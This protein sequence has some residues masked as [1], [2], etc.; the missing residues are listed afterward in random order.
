[1]SK[2]LMATFGRASL[3]LSTFAILVILAVPKGAAFDCTPCT[4]ADNGSGTIDY[5]SPCPHR[6]AS[7]QFASIID[8]LPQ[9]TT[10]DIPMEIVALSLSS[11]TPGGTLNGEVAVFDGQLNLP[12]TGTGTLAG[13]ARNVV[14]T[15][16]GEIHSA[17]RTPG[18]PIQSFDTDMFRLQG[19]ITGD[20]DFD[21][22]R[23]T[24]GTAF[25]MP[26]G[27]HVTILKAAGSN[28]W[29]GDG[30]F[31]I[32]YRIDFVGHPG[33]PLGG[34]SGST[35]GTIRVYQGCP[36]W[37]AGD[38]HK[39]HFPQLPNEAGWDVAAT[40]PRFLADDFRCSETG[41]IKDIHFWG[42]WLNGQRGRIR[43]FRLMIL[44]DV[45]AGTDAPY[46]HP[47]DTLW[48]GF[49]QQFAMTPITPTTYEGWFNPRVPLFLSDNHIEYWQYDILPQPTEWFEQ[50]EGTIYWLAVSAELE[51]DPISYEWGWKSSYLHFNDDAVFE[52]P[53]PAGTCE[54]PDNGGGT[55]TQPADCPYTSVDPMVII[56]GLPAGTTIECQPDL[57]AFASV[58]ESPGGSLSGTTSQ[59]FARLELRMQGTGGLAA[60]SRTLTIVPIQ[61][62]TDQGPR[63]PGTSP[64][65]FDTEMLQ[66][67]G[68]ITGDPD[69]DLLRI[70]AGTGFGM[71]SPGHTTLIMRPGGTW[72]VDSFFDI[73]YRI[74]F[75]GRPGGALGGM[76]GSTTATIR[77]SQGTSSPPTCEAPD[78]GGGTA[79]Q[80]A[81]CPITS[82]D[83]Y[84]I[85]DG[86][87]VGTT[88]EC[89]PVHTPSLVTEAPGGT[90]GGTASECQMTLELQLAGTGSLAGYSRAI[91]LTTSPP[92]SVLS[93]AG[94]RIP[95]TTPQ[96]FDTEMLQM[97]LQ[98]PIGDPDFDLL[99][100]T[101]G[102][103]FGMPSPGHTTLTRMPGGSWSVDSFFDIT[104]RIDFVGHPGGPLGGMSGS[105]TGTIRISQGGPYTPTIPWSELFEPPSFA[106]SL[107]L[108]FV[109]TNGPGP[110][111]G[112]CCGPDGSCFVSTSL[113]CDLQGG[114]YLG[115]GTICLGDA[116]GDGVDD[117]CGSAIVRGACCS[118][119]GLCAVMTPIGCETSGGLYLGNGTVCLGD[120]DG[121]GFD[122]ACQKPSKRGACC[123]PDGSCSVVTQD[124]C[125]TNGGT[126]LGDGTPCLG[127][128]N[129]NQVDD[130]CERPDPD[131]KWEQSPDLEPT[132]M[133]V[134]ASLTPD[135]PPYVLADDFLCSVTGPITE[136]HVFGSWFRDRLPF[137]DPRQVRFTLSIHADI[138]AS[139]TGLYSRPGEL[140]CLLV[141]LPFIVKPFGVE[142]QEGFMIPP[143]NWSPWPNGDKVCW[144][145]IFTLPP[146][147]CIQQ[148]TAANPIVYWLDVQATPG[149]QG[150]YFGWKTTREHWNDDATYAVGVDQPGGVLPWQELIYPPNHPM[151]GQSIDLA[152]KIIGHNGTPATGACCWPD[153]SC[154]VT[155]QANCE[156]TA[157][158]VIGTYQGDGSACLGDANNNGVDDAC[159]DILPTGA[160]CFTGAAGPTC[161]NTTQAACINVY[162]GTWYP[163]QN[164]ATFNC[165]T[166]PPLGACC[167]PDAAGVMHCISTTH[168]ECVKVYGGTWYLGQS[169]ADIDCPTPQ[170]MGACCYGDPASP[171]CVNTTQDL[172]KSQFNGHWYAGQ[173]CATFDCPSQPERGACCFDDPVLGQSCVN[174][175]KAACARIYGGTWYAGQDCAT[176]TCP[177]T[178]P[179][180]ACCYGDPASPL[181]V[182]STQAD[183]HAKYGGTW[184]A[185]QTCATIQC[186]TPPETGACCFLTAAGPG[187]VNSTQLECR[188]IY[189]GTWYAGQSCA[190]F[191][192]PTPVP[193]G[194]CC[195]GVPPQCVTTT[196]DQCKSAYGGTWYAGQTCATFQC[197]SSCCVGRVG[198]ANG[199]G[200]DEPTI[201]DI[202]VMIDAKF[203]TGDC[204]GIIACLPEA[205]IN[206]S[207]GSSPTCDD[208][209][210]GDISILID[211]LFITGNTLIL[212]DCR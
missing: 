12:M 51:P 123:W 87:P 160:C 30:F 182:S 101:A 170:P 1:M 74:D 97:Q 205:D 174:T 13:F 207:G 129:G 38:V 192:C 146:D 47:G 212:P 56:D 139:P 105:T 136:I 72:A 204:A 53:P 64:Q 62:A 150:T 70:T 19:E 61:G 112:A 35:T 131:F 119:D 22:L 125:V 198:D 134:Y 159:E 191:Q 84:M 141:D 55:A 196:D 96:S 135:R 195:F 167:Y 193:T 202:S 145:Y 211:Y 2:W 3:A 152:F 92:S 122:D 52:T 68:Q 89:Q 166:Q 117:A 133:D 155:T 26:G 201:G 148:G 59:W 185:G 4:V 42:S 23:I 36:V 83:P 44:A 45:P 128:L 115:D 86:L 49:F 41:P 11:V 94:P 95:G 25:G 209:T 99:R 24:A 33:G 163:G 82:V 116:D 144:E 81:L 66:L 168:K 138:P 176:F 154:T 197:V 31:D 143:V 165:P 50:V 32:T 85:I 46:S 93:Q 48:S 60:F 79:T 90:M 21:L 179:M 161:L 14:M 69:F 121:D 118:P 78:N 77:M 9:G 91:T 142:L 27:G 183:C 171:S 17:P 29:H 43:G 172:C 54:V 28:D 178:V 108:A 39:M 194:V 189:G 5:P 169:C 37:V 58:L 8:G 88:I 186:P 113:D 199:S 162:A 110:T 206:Q 114:T 20:P 104:Y 175:S 107:D 147:L 16:A 173:D 111:I 124:K 103:G 80:P 210:I 149:E 15:A 157:T 40:F 65:S 6:P 63:A 109:I 127:D 57:H 34:M 71:P 151:G 208:V 106:Q 164:C 7:G 188:A 73:T 184:Y 98:G 137:G 181:C 76:S 140:L 18:D 102:S 132:G 120:N 100:I 187:C 177:N 190:T 130:A 153:G 10:I 67:Q 180:G 203:I 158:G 75:V 200:D 126:Y 156:H